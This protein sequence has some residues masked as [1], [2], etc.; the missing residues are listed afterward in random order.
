MRKN[1]EEMFILEV[2]CL[3]PEEL[4]CYSYRVFTKNVYNKTRLECGRSS[5]MVGKRIFALT[6]ALLLFAS[7]W[8]SGCKKN[9]TTSSSETVTADTVPTLLNVDV[10]KLLAS[11]QVSAALGVTVG[12]PD[13][14]DSG[15]TAHYATSDEKSSAEISLME[16]DRAKYDTTVALYS[17]AADTPNLGDAAKWSADNKQLLIYGKGYMICVTV[18]VDGK[19]SDTL[20]VAAR[21]LGALVLDKLG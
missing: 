18:D 16:C 21:Q 6:G 3:A 11:D 12:N 2:M 7:F 19:N 5:S 10:S 9:Q 20:R 8:L 17:D 13:I 14:Y 1:Y 15:T 4:L